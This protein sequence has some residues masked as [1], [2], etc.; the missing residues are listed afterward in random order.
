MKSSWLR[1]RSTILAL[2]VSG[3]VVGCVPASSGETSLNDLPEDISNKARES[4]HFIDEVWYGQGKVVVGRLTIPGGVS[5]ET[6]A[7]R[8]ILSPDGYFAAAV[9]P[10][11]TLELLAHGYGPIVI[12]VPSNASRIYR[13]D[14]ISLKRLPDAELASVRGSVSLAKGQSQVPVTVRLKID[15]PP[16]IWDDDGYEGGEMQPVVSEAIIVSGEKFHFDGLSDFPYLVTLGAPQFIE[17]H[18]PVVASDTRNM[19]LGRTELRTAPRIHFAYVSQFADNTNIS[20]IPLA[21]QD[22]ECNGVNTFLMTTQKDELGNDLDLCLRSTEDN[23]VVASFWCSPSQFYDLGPGSWPTVRGSFSPAKIRGSHR[24]MEEQV[25]EN[26]HI[27]YYYFECPD[28]KTTC[29]FEATFVDDA[30]RSGRQ[31]ITILP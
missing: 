25:L 1:I 24:S 6:I 29:L 13:I 18:I 7:S 23:K 2:V 26:G 31:D 20:E 27:Y 11:R 12:R 17:K 21:T 8:T 4:S 14:P 3:I 5:V 30:K 19:D 10:G 9:Y 16:P 22:V 28:M 15:Q